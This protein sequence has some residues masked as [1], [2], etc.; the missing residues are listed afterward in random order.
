MDQ[1]KADTWI[2]KWYSHFI[3]E[4]LMCKKLHTGKF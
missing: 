4:H 2:F 3:H 1:N